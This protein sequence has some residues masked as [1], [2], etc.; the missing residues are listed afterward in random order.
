MSGFKEPSFTDRQKAAQEARK[1]ILSK[2]TND[3]NFG[4]NVSIREKLGK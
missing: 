2:L 1:S 4:H 3:T